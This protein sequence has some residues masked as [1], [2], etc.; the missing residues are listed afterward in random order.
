M[1]PTR[2]FGEARPPAL[3]ILRKQAVRSRRSRRRAG[4]RDKC[5]AEHLAPLLRQMRARR[6]P[7]PTI[8][9]SPCRGARISTVVSSACCTEPAQTCRRSLEPAV[10]QCSHA[11]HPVRQGGT[12]PGRPRSIGNEGSG[13]SVMSKNMLS[14]LPHANRILL[15]RMPSSPFALP[16]DVPSLRRMIVENEALLSQREQP[17]AD[18]EALLAERDRLIAVHD[19]LGEARPRDRAA[20]ALAR[21]A[22]G[23]RGRE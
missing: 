10:Q 21:R 8:A 13:V 22:R 1:R 7:P 14:G 9:R 4:S 12:G 17:I 6:A 2:Y 11:A 20:R 16:R 3:R 23:R 19:F 18:K 15:M 5:R